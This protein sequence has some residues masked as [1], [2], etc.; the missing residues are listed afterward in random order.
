MRFEP[1]LN[2]LLSEELRNKRIAGRLLPKY[3]LRYGNGIRGAA[4]FVR[5]VL[6]KYGH[7]KGTTLSSEAKEELG[8]PGTLHWHA[9]QLHRQGRVT[10]RLI[11][12]EL[13][14]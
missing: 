8:S 11:T 3:S 12:R 4:C 2:L 14:A 10:G 5:K 1:F 13:V 6:S 7:W 9:D